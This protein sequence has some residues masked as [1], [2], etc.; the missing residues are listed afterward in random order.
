MIRIQ[1]FFFFFFFF[2]WR[3]LVDDR[4]YQQ[5]SLNWNFLTLLIERELHISHR[6][7]TNVILWTVLFDS[8]FRRAESEL[9]VSWDTWLGC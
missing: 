9:P 7:A 8:L 6:L 1:I 2:F 4:E 3:Q 5:P